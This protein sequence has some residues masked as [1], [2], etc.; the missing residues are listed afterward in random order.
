[1]ALLLL[2]AKEHAKLVSDLEEEVE[3]VESGVVSVLLS[4][5]ADDLLALVKERYEVLLVD[6]CQSVI[7][8]LGVGALVSRPVLAILKLFFQLQLVFLEQ[9]R[10]VLDPLEVELLL[11]DFLV[12]DYSVS[13]LRVDH[14]LA[15][16]EHVVVHLLIQSLPLLQVLPNELISRVALEFVQVEV[17]LAH[18]IVL[19]LV[20]GLIVSHHLLHHC[21][22]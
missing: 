2:A 6:L 10:L 12:G 9:D 22:L 5:G 21:F 16:E 18:N 4:V 20:D 13:L 17:S 11:L 7:L 8:P 15:I 3:D 14:S 19:S 1:M